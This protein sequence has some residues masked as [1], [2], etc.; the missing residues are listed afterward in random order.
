MQGHTKKL[1]L[2]TFLIDNDDRVQLAMDGALRPYARRSMPRPFLS[3]FLDVSKF[4]GWYSV[5]L[6]KE[7]KLWVDRCFAV[8]LVY[9]STCTVP[10]N[11]LLLLPE[12]QRV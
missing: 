8:S 4:I 10:C 5:L 12:Q 11:A 2:I 6:H 9:I 7:M 1:E 3:A